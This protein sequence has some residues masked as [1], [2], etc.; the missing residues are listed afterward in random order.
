[1]MMQDGFYLSYVIITAELEHIS[2]ATTGTSHQSPQDH[3]LQIW[4]TG[5]FNFGQWA[6]ICIRTV[7][8][9]NGVLTMSLHL[10]ITLNLMAR[11]R[12]QSN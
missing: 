2:R 11:Q 7:L 10:H 9:G 12:M 6:P 3:V 1:M 5:C 4:G 8:Q